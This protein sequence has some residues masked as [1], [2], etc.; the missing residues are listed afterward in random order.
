MSREPRALIH[1]LLRSV[2][3]RVRARLA[4]QSALWAL[5][6]GCLLLLLGIGAEAL[7][8]LWPFSPPVFTGFALVVMGWAVFRTLYLALRPIPAD[9]VAFLIEQEH[10]ELKNAL[11]S[12]VQLTAEESPASESS[13]DLLR[14]LL[15]NT[16]EQVRGVRPQVAADR[17]RMRRPLLAAV[18]AGAVT[19][20][21]GLLAPG[22]LKGSV[23][24]LRHP[25]AS[26]P[27]RAIVLEVS[28]KGE[29]VLLGG[30]VKIDV[31]V[32]GRLPRDV[33]LEL[34]PETGVPERVKM[35]PSQ[36]GKFSYET[37]PVR[38][39]FTYRA[40]AERH[41]SPTY[42]IDAVS[43]PAIEVLSLHY[44][45][46]RYT[47]LA[48][49]V[50]E[51][52]G[53][54]RGL[55]GTEVTLELQ[56]NKAVRAG[57]IVF[58]S[59][60][61]FP[62]EVLEGRN[63]RGQFLLL[64]NDDY[65]ILLE[66]QWGFENLEPV[67]YPIEII[68]DE[69]PAIELIF[70]TDEILQVDSREVIP[71]GYV[72]RD[73]FGIRDIRVVAEGS[74]V[75]RREDGISRAEEARRLE[76]GQHEWDLGSLPLQ[77]GSVLRVHLEAKDNDQISGPK[78]AVSRSFEIRV[79]S[80][81]EDHQ[82]VRELQRE[83]AERLIGLL[84]DQLELEE[85]VGDRLEKEE[86]A[87][88]TPVLPPEEADP[89]SE[90]AEHIEQGVKGLLD[91]ISQTLQQVARDPLSG[92]DAFTDL[93]TLR[94]N[95]S[96]LRR[97]MIPRARRTLEK[98][99]PGLEATS[100][101]GEDQGSLLQKFQQAQ[102]EITAELER[103]A[104]L[105]DDI[106]KRSGIRDLA[107]I[108]ERLAQAQN[109]LLDAFDQ[110]LREG[111]LQAREALSE[112]LKKVEELLQELARGFQ[113]LPI[114][115]PDEFLNSPLGE[116]ADLGDLS[117][118]LQE[119]QEHLEAG[120]LEEA[121]RLAEELIQSLSQM[122][123]ALQGAIG[124]ALAGLSQEFGES[125]GRETG[126]LEELLRRQRAILEE[127]QDV[128]GPLRERLYGIQEEGYE[129]AIVQGEEAL[130]RLDQLAREVPE[131]VLPLRSPLRGV[132]GER[133]NM[134]Q[135][136]LEQQKVPETVQ[137]ARALAELS[138]EI[139]RRLESVT[140]DGQ[141]LA[142]RDEAVALAEEFRSLAKDLEGLP[143]DPRLF[144]TPEEGT[145]L[146]ELEKEQRAVHEETDT[147]HRHLEELS[148]VLP[149]IG[150]E[151]LQNLKLAKEAMGQAAGH[152]LEQETREAIPPEQE[153]VYRLSRARSNAQRA[154]G[155]MARR[156]RFGASSAPG[157]VQPGGAPSLGFRY[158]PPTGPEEGGRT[159]VNTR[160][161]ELP[162]KDAYKVPKL[163]RE[164]VIEALKGKYPPAYKEQIERYFKNL[165]E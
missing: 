87:G 155:Q 123:A 103:M 18:S 35:S 138:Q 131:G 82:D 31:E 136:S 113:N 156:G 99:V 37:D 141:P 117:Q 30:R 73:D 28:P 96:Y 102:K 115:L 3:R 22:V 95:L 20:A 146:A 32:Q 19:L 65:R 157:L 43:P 134:L 93:N 80:P 153:A 79:S 161:F 61:E 86:A 127:T 77:P 59:R 42:Q 139:A 4:A 11:I 119:I 49:E 107:N 90:R 106:G 68:P 108:G 121:R 9:H 135:E 70:P 151:V 97:E 39:S 7:K 140:L 81:H 6:L 88:Q 89:L 34:L 69:F 100:P 144:L 110:A 132:L 55:K 10:P 16:S 21:V 111:S 152:L 33:S 1:A 15:E 27:S 114:Q 116:M 118:R 150:P 47:G 129:A 24:L 165:V 101:E 162:T 143:K 112:A 50:Q 137:G 67:R 158:R 148:R 91:Q 17:S 92:F 40:F 122:I 44:L 72:A 53:D 2:G 133:A 76:S 126:V 52:R 8:D 54:V 36:G 57:R 48:S 130:D 38:S 164:E 147:V 25:V 62:L 78:V 51:G 159:G 94:S 149:F 145:Q 41:S 56:A 84:G 5:T 85:D 12:S 75:G 160:D 125:A 128:E 120:A 124:E 13:P 83:I 98:R 163:H 45:Y 26:I 105:A 60:S 23:D 64:E 104:L 14:A 109:Q 154:M 63:L 74:G 58:G 46:P 66:D 29:R 142:L 71:M